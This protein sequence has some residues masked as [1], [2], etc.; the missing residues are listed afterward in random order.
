MFKLSGDGLLVNFRYDTCGLCNRH[1]DARW[2]DYNVAKAFESMKLEN[3]N[4]KVFGCG[5]HYH[6]KCL[7][8]WNIENGPNDKRKDSSSL[9]DLELMCPI[10]YNE[11]KVEDSKLT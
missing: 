9:E 10:C 7:V 1:Y 3:S 8:K 5:H 6:E 2:R 11:L 4:L